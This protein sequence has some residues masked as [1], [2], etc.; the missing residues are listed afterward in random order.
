MER[1]AARFPKRISLADRFNGASEGT[2][3]S[4]GGRDSRPECHRLCDRVENLRRTGRYSQLAVP[5][6][7]PEHPKKKTHATG[8]DRSLPG[9]LPPRERLHR[10]PKVFRPSAAREVNRHLVSA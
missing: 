6:A 3:I 9:C 8:G 7:K 4:R 5:I 10:I 1:H 2:V